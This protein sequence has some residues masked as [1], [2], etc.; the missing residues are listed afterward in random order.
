MEDAVASKGRVAQMGSLKNNSTQD[1]E[2]LIRLFSHDGTTEERSGVI[3]LRGQ[4][5]EAGEEKKGV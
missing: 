3:L 1:H 4:L 5:G 2:G